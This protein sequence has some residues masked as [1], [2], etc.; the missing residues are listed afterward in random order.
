MWDKGRKGVK[1]WTKWD[2]SSLGKVARVEFN[3]V[4]SEELYESGY[5]LGAP[6]YFAY[7]DVAV[8]FE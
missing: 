3:L 1:E 4:G 7:D 2:L 8:I 6:G 5:G